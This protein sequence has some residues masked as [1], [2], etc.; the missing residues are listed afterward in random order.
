MKT[1]W[2]QRQREVNTYTYTYILSLTIFVP[3]GVLLFSYFLSFFVFLLWDISTGRILDFRRHS[4]RC[5]MFNNSF[6]F[7]HL[8]HKIK[9]VVLE[10]FSFLNLLILSRMYVDSHRFSHTLLQKLSVSSSLK[11]MFICLNR[12]RWLLFYAN[13]LDLTFKENSLQFSYSQY[14]K[15]FLLAWLQNWH[16]LLRSTTLLHVIMCM[17]CDSM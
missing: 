17:N 10:P 8:V 3:L 1:Q 2:R 12:Y 15:Q 14:F 7:Y 4:S 11:I 6:N 9:Q 5:V 16:E 13:K